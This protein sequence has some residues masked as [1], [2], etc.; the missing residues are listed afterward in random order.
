M[1]DVRPKS[2]F[3]VGNNFTADVKISSFDPLEYKITESR[4]CLAEHA[5]FQ[6]LT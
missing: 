2:Y 1:I 4:G 5:P 3:T 6:E